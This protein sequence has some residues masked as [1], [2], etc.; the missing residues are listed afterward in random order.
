MEDGSVN[1]SEIDRVVFLVQRMPL[2]GSPATS[3]LRDLLD[4][5]P[6]RGVF[7]SRRCA[8]AARPA[9]T[10]RVYVL[11]QQL[12]PALGDRVRV[13]SEERC[14]SR[15]S[16]STDLQRLQPRKQPSLP[17]I[18]QSKEQNNCGFHLVR[19]HFLR[20]PDLVLLDGLPSNDGGLSLCRRA[21]DNGSPPCFCWQCEPTTH[22]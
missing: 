14:H 4:L 17:L 21:R 1:S 7:L 18:E 15:I 19:Q 6:D 22:A 10:C 11:T 9:N 13:D 2:I 12:D 5:L 8:A 3:S 16:P 20:P